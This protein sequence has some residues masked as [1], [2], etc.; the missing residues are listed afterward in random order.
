MRI[1]P[2]SDSEILI[3]A[4]I[5]FDEFMKR[6]F[7][8]TRYSLTKT[9]S[10]LM[11]TLATQSPLSMSAI[12]QRLSIPK[13]Q[14]TRTV[15]P[16]VASGLVSKARN[17]RNKRIVEISLTEEGINHLRL[18][19]YQAQTFVN[20]VLSTLSEQEREEFITAAR[21]CSMH[22]RKSVMYNY[23]SPE[24]MLCPSDSEEEK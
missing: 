3:E 21:T 1:E 10:D 16:L 13:E 11:F 6:T 24:G 7:K 17:D 23:R 22:L 12:S 19:H 9:Q 14:A 20:G 8:S 2:K 4:A 15:Q 5:Y 18:V